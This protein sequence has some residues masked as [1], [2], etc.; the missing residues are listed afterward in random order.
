MARG[1]LLYEQCGAVDSAYLL[2]FWLVGLKLSCWGLR[3]YTCYTVRSHVL[4]VTLVGPQPR[5]GDKSVELRVI[6]P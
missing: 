1:L 5:F 2:L 4:L 3:V 6:S